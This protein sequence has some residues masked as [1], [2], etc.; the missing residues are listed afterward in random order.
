MGSGCPASFANAAMK[1]CAAVA[2]L[3]ADIDGLCGAR[4]HR[5][6]KGGDRG[7]QLR[8]GGG[9]E[10]GDIEDEGGGEAL[11]CGGVEA[12][13]NAGAVPGIERTADDLAVL[14]EEAERDFAVHR[15]ITRTGYA[16]LASTFISPR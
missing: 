6:Q 12:E 5:V 15:K 10:V 13:G 3:A 2:G 4:S 1:V 11:G 9:G 7:V 16:A 14:A 8:V